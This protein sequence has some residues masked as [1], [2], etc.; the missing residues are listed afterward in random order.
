MTNDPRT[1]RL[2]GAVI[3]MTV[4]A[5]GCS[6]T[7]IEPDPETIGQPAITDAP[8]DDENATQDP[9]ADDPT[10]TSVPAD[11]E[12]QLFTDSFGWFEIDRSQVEVYTEGHFAYWW[13]ARFDSLEQA[14]SL[15]A[16]AAE[17]QAD[18]S[19]LGVGPPGAH[20]AG[21]YTNVFLHR[22][23]DD[24]F[25]GFFGNGT[26]YEGDDEGGGPVFAYLAYPFDEELA[27]NRVN[28]FHEL[29]HVFQGTK[30]YDGVALDDIDGPFERA[31]I[32]EAMAEW[33]QMS[34]VGHEQDRAFENVHSIAA[35]PEL[36][37]WTF[38]PRVDT[39]GGAFT[40]AEAEAL[41][42]AAGIRQYANGAFLYYLTDVVGVDAELL[43]EA[44][45]LDPDRTPQEILSERLGADTFRAHYT[46]WA[47]GNAAG[48]DYVT[49]AQ[50]ERA[51][52]TFESFTDTAPAGA[53]RPFAIDLDGAAAVG[54][55]MP[56]ESHRPG[57]WAYNVARVSNPQPGGSTF[58][59]TGD[60][61][62]SAGTP[63]HFELRI[64]IRSDDGSTRQVDATMADD[65]NGSVTVDVGRDDVEVLV[66][67][68]S[69]PD[70]FVGETET[71]GY[72]LSI[73]A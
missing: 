32:V 42:Y 10:S 16:V 40:E 33:Y 11:G 57:A 36:P 34:R 43:L 45:Y 13:D 51:R 24:V 5:A 2:V 49:P 73:D 19:A 37:L 27:A 55:H 54:S 71:F 39:E 50:A 35:S 46:A 3:G 53:L 12:L 30:T 66:V 56:V 44:M 48:F 17:V 69:T 52:A 18:L 65:R 23:D 60:P 67:I 63:S 21:Y 41:D 9:P 47:A 58:A 15:A 6:T 64:V 7:V 4:I 59:L 28:L 70:S 8:A 62:G 38:F 1:Q 14:K 26:G 22:G 68:A 25:P 61:T 72:S 31:W 29:F 20:A